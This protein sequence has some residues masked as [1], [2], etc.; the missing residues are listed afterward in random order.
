MGFK[1]SWP[2][3]AKTKRF[4]AAAEEYLQRFR[5]EAGDG[6]HVNR[7]KWNLSRYWITPRKRSV[8]TRAT[9]R[10]IYRRRQWNENSKRLI[11]PRNI[12]GFCDAHWIVFIPSRYSLRGPS[13]PLK[14]KTWP[15]IVNKKKKVEC[16]FHKNAGAHTVRLTVDEYFL[17][18]L[19]L[20]RVGPKT[21]HAVR[22]AFSEPQ[23]HMLSWRRREV[24]D[25]VELNKGRG[26][27][28]LRRC[29]HIQARVS[30][31]KVYWTERRLRGKIIKCVVL[32]LNEK[33]FNSYKCWNF[34][35]RICLV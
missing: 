5:H 25:C 11:L 4:V 14:E 7:W 29:Q 12:Y 33:K 32:F 24:V 15:A 35:F 9:G 34:T 8:T 30:V 23:F 26:R 16:R 10:R 22:T 3:G 31:R 20:G 27:N 1:N 17:L 21:L 19:W 18:R 28:S 6:S 2:N 13:K